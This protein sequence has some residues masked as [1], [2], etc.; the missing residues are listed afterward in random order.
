[1]LLA[2]NPV[3]NDLAHYQLQRGFDLLQVSAI[4]KITLV[5]KLRKKLRVQGLRCF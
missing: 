2:A 5:E 3:Y 1:M 4:I